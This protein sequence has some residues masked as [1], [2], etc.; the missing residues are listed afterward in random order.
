MNCMQKEE[1]ANTKKHE[2][3]LEKMHN[4]LK[5][6]FPNEEDR[7]AVEE[8]QKSMLDKLNIVYNDIKNKPGLSINKDSIVGD[9]FKS[10]IERDIYEDQCQM[11]K[12]EDKLLHHTKIYAYASYLAIKTFEAYHRSY[13]EPDT[14]IWHIG[15]GYYEAICRTQKTLD[16]NIDDMEYIDEINELLD[17]VAKKAFYIEKLLSVI[18][19]TQNTDSDSV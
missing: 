18:G 17:S 15:M 14:T 6:N 10:I 9:F 12:D 5:K 1:G 11:L 16:S 13:Q 2:E 3:M 7:L 4:T 8:L 19:E